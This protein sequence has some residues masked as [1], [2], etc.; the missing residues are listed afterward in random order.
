M[1]WRSRWSSRTRTGCRHRAGSPSRGRATRHSPSAWRH[2]VTGGVGTGRDRDRN[3]HP[4]RANPATDWMAGH[5]RLP[6]WRATAGARPSTEAAANPATTT[7]STAKDPNAHRAATVSRALRT[8]AST[9]Y[10]PRMA[11]A[12]AKSITDRLHVTVRPPGTRCRRELAGEKK[13]SSGGDDRDRHEGGHLGPVPRHADTHDGQGEDDDPHVGGGGEVVALEAHE[14]Q[15]GQV[16]Q[17]EGRGAGAVATHRAKA[18]VGR[19]GR[20]GGRRGRSRTAAPTDEVAHG[21]EHRPSLPAPAHHEEGDH[22]HHGGDAHGDQALGVAP[23]HGEA[24]GEG[25]HR[26]VAHASAP[27]ATARRWPRTSIP[28]NTSPRC[29]AIRRGRSW[30]PT[31]RTPSRRRRR[32]GGRA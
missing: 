25:E 16:R 5:T 20:A 32:P 26:H 29:G 13:V 19:R 4:A 28:P 6:R 14:Q 22:E 12:R 10:A 15:V 18:P 7:A 27:R 2:P 8:S 21:A 30:G 17:G 3:H 23:V 24:H 1:W 9:P 31:A 11:S